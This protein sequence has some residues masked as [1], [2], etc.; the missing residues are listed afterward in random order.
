M[1]TDTTRKPWEELSQLAESG[2]SQELE[3]FLHELPASDTALALSRL[4]D[5]EQ[6]Q[7]VT[8]LAPDQAADLVEQLP[9]VQAVELIE[10][11]RLIE[12]QSLTGR[13]PLCGRR[14]AEGEC[15]HPQCDRAAV[16]SKPHV[17]SSVVPRV[18]RSGPRPGP[19][20]P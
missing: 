10:R 2:S 6:T 3:T 16:V 1:E 12:E 8:T 15:D 7:V 18:R 4:S 13:C 14:H 9:D 17:L 19:P 5:A 11:R 20:Q